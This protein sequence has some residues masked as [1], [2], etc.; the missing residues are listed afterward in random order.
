MFTYSQGIWWI[1]KT[2]ENDLI[3][4]N[5]KGQTVKLLTYHKISQTGEDKDD[6]KD[7][8]LWLTKTLKVLD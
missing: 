7:T 5:V 3:F 2:R 8:P 1:W 4:S 6:E